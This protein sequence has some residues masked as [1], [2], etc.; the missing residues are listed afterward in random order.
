MPTLQRPVLCLGIVAVVLA[1]GVARAASGEDPRAFLGALL[2]LSAGDVARAAGGHVVAK[3]LDASD[4]EVAVLGLV[5]VAVPP[6][7]YASRMAD[8]E[9][10]KTDEAVLQ[11]G[12]FGTPAR[13]A[14][15][16][17][18]T[19]E[20]SD[21]GKLRECKVRDCGV[22]M[23]AAFIEAFRTGVDW[24]SGA[25]QSQ[26][27]V[28]MRRSL[29]DYVSSY[30]SGAAGMITY[31]SDDK[32]L[33]MADVFRKIVSADDALLGRVP[34]LRGYLLAGPGHAPAGLSS[35]I[36]WSKEKVG[37]K[38]VISVT[39]MVTYRPSAMPPVEYVVASKQ[40]YATHYFEASLGLTFLVRDTASTAPATYVSYVN[41]SRVDAFGGFFGAIARKIVR[42]RARSGLEEQMQKL[43]VRLERE[44]AAS[45]HEPTS[46]APDRAP[47][48]A[49]ARLRR[50]RR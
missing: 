31:E 42:S 5:R 39:D 16:R 20:S 9:T 40:L 34:V 19:L 21:V 10:F 6:D 47:A 48:L 3:T 26:A 4:D 50:L 25:A 45:V 12:A 28:V 32:P 17:E 30:R 11:I 33:A 18:L 44:Y 46:P 7:F 24:H 29:V 27:D 13:L 1:A 14:D 15:I 41:R 37:R 38:A 35:Q 22:H 8:I 23:P 49:G 2:D 36:Y 43:K